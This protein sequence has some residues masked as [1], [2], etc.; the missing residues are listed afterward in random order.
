MVFD[1]WALKARIYCV[2]SQVLMLSW[3]LAIVY[4][5]KMTITWTIFGYLFSIAIVASQRRANLKKW[6]Y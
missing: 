2:F 3:H 6:L 5:K 1:S 4:A